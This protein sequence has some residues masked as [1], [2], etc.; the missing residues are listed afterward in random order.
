MLIAR[1]LCSS[2]L[3][4]QHVAVA[5]EVGV[6]PGEKLPKKVAVDEVPQPV[7]AALKRQFPSAKIASAQLLSTALDSDE[8]ELTVIDG[9]EQLEVGVDGISGSYQVN[10]IKKPIAVADVPKAVRQ[11]I[12]ERHPKAEIKNA[13]EVQSGLIALAP[14]KTKPPGYEAMIV[15]AEHEKCKIDLL[16]GFRR[17]AKGEILP[18]PSKME[19]YGES[20]LND[21][22]K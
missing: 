13:W 16:P 19:I 22:N 10:T 21:G 4:A 20:I 3:F 1:L 11:A 17:T 9:K 15:T 6:A 7:V 12:E 8:W 14:G 18:D 2:V 5:V